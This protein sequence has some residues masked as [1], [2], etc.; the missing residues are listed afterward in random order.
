MVTRNEI[1]SW[2]TNGGYFAVERPENCSHMLVVCDTFDWSDY[3]VFVL[4]G[5]DVNE[6]IK[7]Y[8]KNMQKV[9]EVYSYDLPLQ[10]QLDSQKAWN[11]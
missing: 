10:Q 11:I 8:S 4:R 2:L 5:Q 3:P 1:K 7:E 9:M 6:K